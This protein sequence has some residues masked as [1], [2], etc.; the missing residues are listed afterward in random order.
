MSKPKK[1]H[2]AL[3]GYQQSLKNLR[4]DSEIARKEMFWVFIVVVVFV[5]IGIGLVLIG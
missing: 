2:E 4:K 5:I 3:K 1:I